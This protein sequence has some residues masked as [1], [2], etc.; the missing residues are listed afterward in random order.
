MGTLAITTV[1]SPLLANSTSNSDADAFSLVFVKGMRMVLALSIA[2][3]AGL[4]VLREDLVQLLFQW[5]AFGAS[6]TALT[7]PIVGMYAFVFPCIRVRGF[8]C[9]R[10]MLNSK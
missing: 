4:F 2:S 7:A 1:F 9:E 8:V 3:A 6:D 10:Y 5:G